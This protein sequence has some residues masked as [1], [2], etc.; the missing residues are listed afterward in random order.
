[1]RSSI[2]AQSWESVPPAPERTVTTASP[3]SYSPLNSRASSSSASRDSTEP[4]CES[5]SAAISASS[6]AISASSSRSAASASSAAE[7]SRAGAARARARP[8]SSAARSWSSQKPGAPISPSS[9]AISRFERGRVKGSP[10]AGSS[11]GGSPR[12]AALRPPLRVHQPRGQLS[13]AASSELSTECLLSTRAEYPWVPWRY[14]WVLSAPRLHRSRSSRP[15]GA[16]ERRAHRPSIAS[17]ASMIEAKFW[18][19]RLIRPSRTRRGRRTVSRRRARRGPPSSATGAAPRRHVARR[20]SRGSR[21]PRPAR[22]GGRRRRA[23]PSRP[24]RR[25]PRRSP[26]RRSRQRRGAAR[27]RSPRGRGLEAR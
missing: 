17:I 9:R 1:M 4:S 16:G 22:R 18:R 24:P 13:G 10:R 27:P 14:R 19:Q 20:R 23:S 15:P 25:R 21:R 26:C 12:S 6:A 3:A 11:P 8:R 2:S 5:S 7:A